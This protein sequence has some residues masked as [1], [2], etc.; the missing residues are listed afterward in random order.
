MDKTFLIDYDEIERLSEKCIDCTA[1][2]DEVHKLIRLLKSS[3]PIIREEPSL[4]EGININSDI[5]NIFNESSNVIYDEFIQVLSSLST[6]RLQHTEAQAFIAQLKNITIEGDNTD[7][8]FETGI[9]KNNN[10]VNNNNDKISTNKWRNPKKLGSFN[11][12]INF[13]NN[14]K[15]SNDGSVEK[16]NLFMAELNENRKLNM[17]TKESDN[18]YSEKKEVKITCKSSTS[19]YQIVNKERKF[20]EELLDKN[21]DLNFRVYTKSSFIAFEDV[22]STFLSKHGIPVTVQE[23]IHSML[24]INPPPL[25]EMCKT[26]VK[27]AKNKTTFD[28]IL[29]SHTPIGIEYEID[30]IT[31]KPFTNNKNKLKDKDLLFNHIDQSDCLKCSINKEGTNNNDEIKVKNQKINSN[32]V[33]SDIFIDPDNYNFL[34]DKNV[35]N[36]NDETKVSSSKINSNNDFSASYIGPNN[37][38]FLTDTKNLN[39][40]D[41][42]K[43]NNQDSNFDGIFLSCYANYS[44]NFK[45]RKA[46]EDLSEDDESQNSNQKMKSVGNIATKFESNKKKYLAKRHLTRYSDDSFKR[47]KKLKVDINSSAESANEMSVTSFRLSKATPIRRFQKL[48]RKNEDD[49][50]PN[51]I[52]PSRK[53]IC[54]EPIKI[55]TIEKRNLKRKFSTVSQDIGKSNVDYILSKSFPLRTNFI[56][57]ASSTPIK[58]QRSHSNEISVISDISDISDISSIHSLDNVSISSLNRN[59][60]L[61]SSNDS[62]EVENRYL[63]SETNNQNILTSCDMNSDNFSN[64]INCNLPFFSTISSG[65]SL[66]SD[67]SLKEIDLIKQCIAYVLISDLYCASYSFKFVKCSI[68]EEDVYKKFNELVKGFKNKMKNGDIEM[69]KDLKVANY[70]EIKL[71]FNLVKICLGGTYQKTLSF[72]IFNILL[73]EIVYI[74]NLCIVETCIPD[75]NPIPFKS[76]QYI[77]NDD[78]Y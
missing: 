67:F 65:I 63:N 13:I 22:P 31:L 60:T 36:K 35:T 30:A 7:S 40:H 54:K 53:L 46:E 57:G 5:L 42:S 66:D 49:S 71:I 78:K 56:P 34:I 14:K 11:V 51:S 73:Y 75:V 17:G 26:I 45:F 10:F 9:H 48:K 16:N 29:V 43:I 8:N 69:P 20:E 12:D 38:V 21:D 74:Y 62:D 25:E 68:S 77:M 58:I 6:F 59:I 1:T 24:N 32:S 3:I 19:I 28:N 64:R 33:C 18:N 55:E 50:L 44:K 61:F 72:D 52:L 47:V 27:Y 15:S 39:K 70:K 23:E 37:Y 4:V 76:L 2:D 41:R